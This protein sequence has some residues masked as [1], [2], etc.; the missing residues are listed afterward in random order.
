MNNYVIN[1]IWS[2]LSHIDSYR[3]SLSSTR[4]S[5][6]KQ[7]LQVTSGV[8][9]FRARNLARKTWQVRP[10]S[11]GDPVDKKLISSPSPVA[12]PGLFLFV[13]SSIHDMFVLAIP[14]T[15]RHSVLDFV[16]GNSQVCEHAKSRFDTKLFQI[17]LESFRIPTCVMLGKVPCFCTA[18]LQPR[19]FARPLV[20]QQHGEMASYNHG[21]VYVMTA[22]S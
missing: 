1:V 2:G 17:I 19:L 11:N 4:T 7:V 13:L 18:R 8:L 3:F 22:G 14:Q 5:R 12:S 6:E 21:Q 10:K 15:S 16:A 9:S 20:S